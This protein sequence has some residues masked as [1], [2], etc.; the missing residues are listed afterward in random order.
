MDIICS[1]KYKYKSLIS[2][3]VQST[4]L[5]NQGSGV[6]F[7]DEASQV[8]CTTSSYRVRCIFLFLSMLKEE[9]WS[10]S[11]QY[12]HYNIVKGGLMKYFLLFL[13][14]FQYGKHY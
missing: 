3:V 11:Q 14:S 10:F 1:L 9:F 13:D 2:S 7:S 12:Q 6:R 8:T 5:V 4:D